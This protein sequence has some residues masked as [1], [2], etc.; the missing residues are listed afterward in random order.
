VAYLVYD[1]I[2][3]V[4]EVCCADDGCNGGV[5]GT[6]DYEDDA[7]EYAEDHEYEHDVAAYADYNGEVF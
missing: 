4:F 1:A 2:N 5:V 7:D 3:A 6:F